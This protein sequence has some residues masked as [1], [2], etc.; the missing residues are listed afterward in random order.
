MCW[1][2][3]LFYNH[4]PHFFALVIRNTNLQNFLIN[5]ISER[6]R[7]LALREDKTKINY[8][9]LR[10]V[11]YPIKHSSQYFFVLVIREIL[12]SAHHATRN[13]SANAKSM[14]RV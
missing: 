8:P 3:V 1:C 13:Q 4:L 7:L 5:D 12:Q 9:R 14:S 10:Q 6:K 11:I 2:N